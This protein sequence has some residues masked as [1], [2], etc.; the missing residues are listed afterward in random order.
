[1]VRNT[2]QCFYFRFSQTQ[3][4]W[5]LCSHKPQFLVFA[6]KCWVCRKN[7]GFVPIQIDYKPKI[8][9]YKPKI[10]STGNVRKQSVWNAVCPHPWASS[11]NH[12]L[13]SRRWTHL[14]DVHDDRLHTEH[15]IHTRVSSFRMCQFV[16]L[17]YRGDNF[18]SPPL[19]VGVI[20]FWEKSEGIDFLVGIDFWDLKN[21][22]YPKFSR[23]RRART[24]I[25]PFKMVIYPKKFA[26]QARSYPFSPLKMII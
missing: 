7:C 21:R 22:G 20:D 6:P 14:T 23:L 5:S 18:N 16:S 10:K 24:P 17:Q 13:L 26:P 9:G 12:V 11:L 25:S 4:F 1:M 3:N 8:F 2:N 15:K 19:R